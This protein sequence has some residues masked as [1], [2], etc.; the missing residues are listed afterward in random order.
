MKLYKK[1]LG[2]TGAVMIG[3]LSIAGC[4]M[5]EPEV[6]IEKVPFEVEKLVEVEKIV[7]VEKEVEVEVVTHVDNGNLDLV[8][9]HLFDNNGDVNYLIDELD[10]DEIDLIVDRIVFINEAKKLAV[11]GLKKDIA[12]ELDKVV[13]RLKNNSTITFDED[14]IERVKCDDDDDEIVVEDCDFED[15]DCD[16]IVTGKFEQDDFKFTFEAVIE[17]KDNQ[18][19]EIKSI[20]VF[21]R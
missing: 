6:I 8:L 13:M 4:S 15:K 18:F 7:E 5:Q 21:E 19:D 11:D 10:D 14:D 20:T 16:V 12:D 2:A 17:I 3:A 1:I 9:E